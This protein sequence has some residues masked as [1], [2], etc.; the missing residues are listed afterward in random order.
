MKLGDAASL[1]FVHLG[2]RPSDESFGKDM[3]ILEKE[4]DAARLK[5]GIADTVKC[6]PV[7]L[8]GDHTSGTYGYTYP[9]DKLVSISLFERPSHSYLYHQRPTLLKNGSDKGH[10]AA[11]ALASSKAANRVKGIQACTFLSYLTF[12]RSFRFKAMM[13]AAAPRMYDL[14]C[15]TDRFVRENAVGLEQELHAAIPSLDPPGT[16]PFASV[17]YNFGSQTVCRRHRDCKNFA[18]GWCAVTSIGNY[19][20]RLGGHLVFWELGLIIEFP[21]GSTILFP[22]ALITHFN[23]TIAPSETRKSIVRYSAGGIFLWAE[24]CRT[25]KTIFRDHLKLYM[26]LDE[27][28]EQCILFQS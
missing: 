16:Y 20:P 6:N 10:L 1:I 23:T 15:E 17:T 11:L 18:P 12:V 7:P 13:K 21:P 8:R 28:D 19:N 4:M 2:G 27:L 9:S 22:S 3:K 14:Y 24:A 25:G 26:T 5:F